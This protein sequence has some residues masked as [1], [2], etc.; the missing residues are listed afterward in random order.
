[1]CPVRGSDRVFCVLSP[2]T[3]CC[4][5]PLYLVSTS[6]CGR[7]WA[8]ALTSCRCG[9]R[10]RTAGLLRVRR[11]LYPSLPLLL[12]LLRSLLLIHAAHTVATAGARFVVLPAVS[13]MFSRMLQSPICSYER[14]SL[15]YVFT[16]VAVSDMFLRALQ[17]PICSYE[18]CSLQYV[19]TSVAVSD[20]VRVLDAVEATVTDKN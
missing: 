11:L 13:D 2:A 8:A 20:D 12:L 10:S 16:S 1:M 19:L 18:R 15:R 9:R 4:R 7:T 5:A 14:C 3:R 17:F 6:R